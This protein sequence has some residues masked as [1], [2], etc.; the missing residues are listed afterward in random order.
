MGS[1]TWQ[2]ARA[3]AKVSLQQ[4]LDAIPVE[5]PSAQVLAQRF[6]KATSKLAAV[7]EGANKADVTFGHA[8]QASEA[9]QAKK[10][11]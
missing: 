1:R 8:K 11:A 10:D 3:A 9:A 6:Q 4:M 2:E 7:Q 5:E